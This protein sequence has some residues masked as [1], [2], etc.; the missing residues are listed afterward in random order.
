[1]VRLLPGGGRAWKERAGKTTRERGVE[2][3]ERGPG[4]REDVQRLRP[5]RVRGAVQGVP[6]RGEEAEGRR[7]RKVQG[8]G[9]EGRNS[10][11][12]LLARQVSWSHITEQTVGD[13]I[14]LRQHAP[15]RDA[16]SP[17]KP[18]LSVGRRVYLRTR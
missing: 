15:A 5:C 16:L 8:N 18:V 1:M 2:A 17:S 4:R 10:G 11:A 12:G 14:S 3:E 9:E 13:P 7:A 6:E